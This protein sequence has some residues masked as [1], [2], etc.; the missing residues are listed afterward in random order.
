MPVETCPPEKKR[1]RYSGWTAT[2]RFV[3]VCLCVARLAHTEAGVFF[4]VDKLC[5]SLL[6]THLHTMFAKVY[7]Q[8]FA[9]SIAENYTTRHVFM[10]LLVLADSEGVV[11]MT[12]GAIARTTNVPLSVVEAAIKELSE[13]DDASRSP[14]EEGRRIALI[15]SHREWGWRIINYGHY[16]QLR[17]E[18]GR[19]AYH[20]DYMREKRR[21]EGVKPREK[22]LRP[23]KSRD[24]ASTHAEGEGDA[25]GKPTTLPQKA[26][27][28]SWNSLGKPF[29]KIEK[30][31][32]GR[33]AHLK[34]RL[35]DP[36]WMS[37]FDDGIAKLKASEFCK[38][39]NDRG[40]VADFD[41]FLK[42]ESLPRIIEGKYDDRN[43]KSTVVLPK[44]PSREDY[45]NGNLQ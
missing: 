40:W 44:A 16:R 26:V 39:K 31:T 43:G 38:G 37:N 42:P 2:F 28:E 1:L 12:M 22:V 8:I 14:E 15:D 25:E 6:I 45:L 13:P 34:A 32:D 30:L 17:D 10:D 33:K 21:K 19:R 35:N 27:V 5:D 11:D 41:F 20:R 36:W 3:V 24:A 18:E 29:P 9:S 7:S 23:V 4:V